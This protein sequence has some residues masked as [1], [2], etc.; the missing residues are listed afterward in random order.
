M[1]GQDSTLAG[2]NDQ[3]YHIYIDTIIQTYDVELLASNIGFIMSVQLLFASGFVDFITLTTCMIRSLP[4]YIHI[5]L[6]PP[7]ALYSTSSYSYDH[8]SKA[9]K[10]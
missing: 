1:C 7:Q 10:D 3:N 5:N 8:I 4:T 9:F 2:H 6:A